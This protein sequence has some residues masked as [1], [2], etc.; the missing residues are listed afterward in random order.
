MKTFIAAVA[1]V[2]MFYTGYSQDYPLTDSLKTNLQ[3]AKTTAE[4]I[5]WLGELASFYIG[6][7]KDLYEDY[8]KQQTQLAELSRDRRLMLFTLLTQA[9]TYYN[10]GDLQE[11][12]DK[13]KKL[14]QQALDLARSSQLDEYVAWAYITL[15]RGER[16][17]GENDKALNYNNLAMSVCSP[18]DND[19]LKIS[20][21]NGMGETYFA[22]KEKLLAF[23]NYIQALNLAEQI[24]NYTQ[25][26]NCYYYLSEFYSDL[27]D[28]EKAKD[29]LFRLQ[30]LTQKNKKPYDRLYVYIEL[31]RIYGQSRKY[32]LASDY[33]EKSISLAD[34]LQFSKFKINVYFA[35]I[36]Q[37]FRNNQSEKA[38]KYFKE[39]KEIVDFIQTEG[40]EYIIDYAYGMAYSDMKKFDSA[41]YYFH[42]AEKRFETKHTEIGRY[43]FYSQYA[44]L[45]T[46]KKEHTKALEYW[47][48]AQTIAQNRGDL[49]LL[50]NISTN[51]D[52][53]Y[54]SL[55]D[56][57][58][59]LYYNNQ[60]HRYKDSLEVLSTEKDLL[61]LEVDNEN[62]RKEREARL[63]E[64]AKRERHNIQYMGIT[65][66]IAGVFIVL[67]MMGAFSVSKTT[68]RILGFFAFIF[69][70]E[71]IILLADH[72]IHDW[73][74]G[75][76]WKILAIKIALISILLPLHHFLEE[77][78]FHYLTSR[79]L[80]EGRAKSL[81]SKIL[82]KS[83]AGTVLKP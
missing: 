65:A 24:D 61:R 26:S 2:L 41:Q 37:Y 54:R 20:A 45:F 51:L 36:N 52:T 79:K 66:G 14:S 76:P 53:L 58:N 28:Y 50:Q 16:N 71:F 48:K 25:M 1:F 43:L 34:T 64:E 55:G 33:Y 83:E 10:Y 32:D 27:E 74:H 17:S 63:A 21:Y 49:E 22:R 4:K 8:T 7:N 70:F 47:Q 23:R 31:G 81:F 9:N 13:G 11:N 39:K 35:I 40:I 5:K 57:K 12:L 42:K 29:Y 59:A 15:A 30:S 82:G 75:E 19:S 72:Q 68:I 77:K 69:L 44:T 56:Y 3:N 73:T 67:V 62:K 46:R 80:L 78:V 18:L 6:I 38:L 60:Y